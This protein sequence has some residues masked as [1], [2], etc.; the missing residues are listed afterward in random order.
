VIINAPA[1][2]AAVPL[3]IHDLIQFSFFLAKH[4][5]NLRGKHRSY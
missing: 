5:S 3:K 1:F 2:D 4:T